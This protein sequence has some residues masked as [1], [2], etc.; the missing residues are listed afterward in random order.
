MFKKDNNFALDSSNILSLPCK[1]N[2]IFSICAIPTLKPTHKS[3]LKTQKE[4][5]Q[6]PLILFKAVRANLA[7]KSLQNSNPLFLV[8]LG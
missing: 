5:E 4:K 3:S 6:R 1:F 2:R 7:A 8:R